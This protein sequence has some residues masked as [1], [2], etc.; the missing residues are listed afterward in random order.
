MNDVVLICGAGPTG[1]VLALWLTKIGIKVRLIDKASSPGTTSRAL[2]IHARTLE[3]Y[4]QL[5]IADEVVERGFRFPTLN[6]WVSHV[7]RAKIS[8]G[9]IGQHASPFPYIIVFPQ[10]K[11][12]EYLIA[13]L[14]D[15]G[16]EVERSTELVDFSQN[17]DGV[18]AKMKRTSG[19]IEEYEAAYLAGCDG[20]RSIVRSKLHTGFEG[21]TY[22]DIF[23]VADIEGSGP[24][25][26]GELHVSL[27]EAQF[28]AVFPLKQIGHGRL[29]GV[30]RA[31]EN[32]SPARWEDVNPRLLKEM[33]V[34]VDKVNWFSTYHVHHRVASHF[35]DRRIF[36]AGDAGHIHSPVGG[37]GMNTGIGD[38]VNLAWKLGDVL[39]GRS[40]PTL[41]D[42]YEPERIRFAR[43]L[44]R[45]TDRAF[46]LVTSTSRLARFVR[47]NLVPR[48]VPLFVKFQFVKRFL[49]R[50]I[51]QTGITYRHSHFNTG[52]AGSLCGG[53]RLPW[54]ESV[55]NFAPLSSLDW[56]I[57][58]YGDKRVNGDGKK[59]FNFQWNSE[60]AEKGLKENV[61]Y[62][63]RP[64]GY[65]GS[66]LEA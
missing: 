33:E 54:V 40:R 44:V 38:A 15:L 50:R 51:S 27:D 59:V 63:I 3:F 58:V 14:R 5:G 1:L 56:Q 42:S 7:R 32:E 12:E 61:T 2:V 23:Y 18:R 20:A 49:F 11:H 43:E 47:L 66:I 9:E 45:T 4:Q 30:I 10:D 17:E 41:L 21:S 36:L 8:I 34:K 60:M 53:D 48:F 6:L 46:I 16:V 28:L 65:I 35:R 39:K 37:Q 29:I 55:D 57:H 13:K 31:N 52:R 22:P 62:L 64:D 26:N 24:V 25:L 19:E